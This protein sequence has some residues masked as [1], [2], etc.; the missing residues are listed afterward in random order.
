MTELQHGEKRV[1]LHSAA[2]RKLVLQTHHLRLAYPIN[3]PRVAKVRLAAAKQAKLAMEELKKFVNAY[4]SRL[5]TS[6]NSAAFAQTVKQKS[7]LRAIAK[8]LWENRDALI[9]IVNDLRKVHAESVIENDA[10]NEKLASR[11]DKAAKWPD[12]REIKASPSQ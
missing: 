5:K 4:E 12:F 3:H 1:G 11:A 9:K 10:R 6:R 7:A 2:F 8:W